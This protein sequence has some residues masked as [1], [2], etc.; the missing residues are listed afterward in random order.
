MHYI[1]QD[2]QFSLLRK[3]TVWLSR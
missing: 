1:L 3:V 2:I